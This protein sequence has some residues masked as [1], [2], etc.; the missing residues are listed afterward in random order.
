MDKI[1][2]IR[3]EIER[4]KDAV[5]T[6]IKELRMPEPSERM[7]G[8]LD[9][10]DDVLWFLDT[11]EKEPD[12]SLEEEMDKFFETMPVLEHENIFEDTFK[13]IARH[14]AKWGTEHAKKDETPV[15]IPNDLEEAAR[16]AIC[17]AFGCDPAYYGNKAEFS[18]TELYQ[19]FIA[20]AKWQAEKDKETIEL[21]EEHAYFAG[22][23]NEREQMLK[24]AVEVK[25]DTTPLHGPV[26][27]T[28]YCSNFPNHPFYKC[29]PGDKVRIIVC[30]KEDEK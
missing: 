22:A 12:K 23:V 7:C 24:D 9:A 14:F 16:D 10:Y 26:G 17:M 15:P 27:I 18:V 8:E 30:K 2:K 3:Q 13:N 25:V 20:G 28:I 5:T 6:T 29:K 19:L 4:L 11:L 1:E 21:A